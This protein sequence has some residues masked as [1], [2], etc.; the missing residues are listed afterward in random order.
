MGIT[1]AIDFLIPKH[2]STYY[3]KKFLMLPAIV[4]GKLMWC[5]T[6][7]EKRQRTEYWDKSFSDG[8]DIEDEF[9]EY[10]DLGDAFLTE[11]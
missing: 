10:C 3:K 11:I 9:V 2:E 8:A 1:G 4:G 5:T 7:L 6:V